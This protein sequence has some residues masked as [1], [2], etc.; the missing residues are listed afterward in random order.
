LG[1]PCTDARSERG[2]LALQKGHAAATTV[3]SVVTTY[4]E[5]FVVL[6]FLVQVRPFP[7]LLL[8]LNIPRHP[9]TL[10]VTDVSGRRHIDNR[11]V[12]HR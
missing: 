8:F 9:V 12:P 2:R 1:R 4:I 3:A 7:R 11:H 10:P 6:V 5:G